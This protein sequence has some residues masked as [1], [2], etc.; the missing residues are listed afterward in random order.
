MKN[1]DKGTHAYLTFALGAEKFAISV[2][3]VQEIVEL[4]QVTKVPNAPQYMLGIINLRGKVLPL[5]GLS[6]T[7]VTKK[8]RIL[9]IDLETSDEKNLQVGALV[10]IAREVIELSTS[11]IQNAPDLENNKTDT[12]I[13]GILNNQGDITMIMDIRK[14]FSTAEIIQLNHSFN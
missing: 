2:N 1:T 3:A 4:E 10:D 9:V 5:L 11:D 14:I 7:G 12:A 8:S 13:T 6:K